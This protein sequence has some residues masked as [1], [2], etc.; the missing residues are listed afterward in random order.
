MTTAV[1]PGTFDPA[2][3]GHIDIA[4]RAHAVFGRLVVA[5]FE[6]PAQPAADRAGGATGAD[7]LAV[8]LEPHLA[9][10]VAGQVPALGFAQQRAEV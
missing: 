7:H 5:V 8:A 6:S 10:G 9:G 1:Y 3:L 2:H 4:E